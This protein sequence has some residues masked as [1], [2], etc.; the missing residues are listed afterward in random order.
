MFIEI[1]RNGS[2]KRI[3]WERG[4]DTP[5]AGSIFVHEAVAQRALPKRPQKQA[6]ALIRPM[7]GRWAVRGRGLAKM[8]GLGSRQG[9]CDERALRFLRLLVPMPSR[10]YDRHPPP[11]PGV[12]LLGK[13]CP[14]F[15]R[16]AKQIVVCSPPKPT[17]LIATVAIWTYGKVEIQ[18]LKTKPPFD[19]ETKRKEFVDKLNQIPNVNIPEDAITRR[20]NIPLSV[21]KE[22][23]ALKQFLEVLD[24]MVGEIHAR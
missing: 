8:P 21:F 6:A 7:G 23:T 14:R 3:P 22:N 15:S 12:R 24:S 17:S 2:S 5:Q 9:E 1:T 19:N 13:N 16:V 4:C 11:P 10:D 20:P 18:W